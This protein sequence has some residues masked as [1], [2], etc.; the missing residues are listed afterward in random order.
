MQVDVKVPVRLVALAE[1]DGALKA[2][3]VVEALDML[4]VVCLQQLTLKRCD[5]NKMSLMSV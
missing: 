1:R 4:S 2:W 3:D 5:E